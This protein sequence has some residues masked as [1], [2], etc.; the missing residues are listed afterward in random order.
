[1]TRGPARGE[2]TSP[3]HMLVEMELREGEQVICLLRS[4]LLPHALGCSMAWLSGSQLELLSQG[5]LLQT[6]SCHPH[7]CWANCRATREWGDQRPKPTRELQPE[8]G[9]DST[10]L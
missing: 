5:W 2:A 10:Q 3:T 4:S 8:P 6:P 9:W 1:M 7:H